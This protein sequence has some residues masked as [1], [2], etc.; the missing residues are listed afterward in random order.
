[1]T[2]EKVRIAD[3]HESEFNPRVALEK[4]SKEYEM[5]SESIREFGLVEPLV[6]NRHNMAVIGGHQRLTVLRDNGVEEVE[7]TFI[8][9]PDPKREKALC[10]ALNKIKGDWDMEKLEALLKDDEV[11][12][13]P[14]GFEEDEINL[15]NLL[16]ESDQ[17][18]DIPDEEGAEE[19]KDK[20]YT[21]I[22]KI[23][24]F[25]FVATGTE[26][27]GLLNSIRDEGIFEPQAIAGEMKRR[28]LNG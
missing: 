9:E 5:I 23:G 6:V 10:V 24:N 12:A 17:E 11:S 14:T 8:N 28:L 15:D 22:I 1:M 3:L 13:F 26:Y 18:L 20:E 2:I 25:S 7:C 27:N 4:G 21:T 19:K 16:G